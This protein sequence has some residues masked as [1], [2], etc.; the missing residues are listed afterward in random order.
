MQIKRI[1]EPIAES[2]GY[3]ILVDRL[4]PRGISKEKAKIDVWAKQI[5]PSPEIRKEFHHNPALMQD[6][7]FKYLHELDHNDDA[8][9][10]VALVR[11]KLAHNNVTLLYAAKSQSVNHATVLKKWIQDQISYVHQ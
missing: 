3:R 1:Y 2:D 6:F 4:W 11:Q 8:R 7:S 9:D 5:A 10:F